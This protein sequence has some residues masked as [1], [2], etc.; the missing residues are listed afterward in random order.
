MKLRIEIN[1]DNAAFDED[2]PGRE[3]ARILSYAAQIAAT[4]DASSP[5]GS[6]RLRDKNGNKVGHL[7][8]S[9]E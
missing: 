1:M 2:G 5:L 8:V 6:W 4:L 9:E 3:S 7:T